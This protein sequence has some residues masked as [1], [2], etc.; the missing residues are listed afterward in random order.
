MLVDK[1]SLSPSTKILYQNVWSIHGWLKWKALSPPSSTSVWFK[2]CPSWSFLV[3]H[4]GLN[5]FKIVNIFHEQHH[6]S[7]TLKEEI[8]WNFLVAVKSWPSWPRATDCMTQQMSH[9]PVKF[10]SFCH[11]KLSNFQKW[12]KKKLTSKRVL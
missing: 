11:E 9:E 6:F 5:N 4:Y 8:F 3:H 7:K 12:K 2:W 1:F 10:Y